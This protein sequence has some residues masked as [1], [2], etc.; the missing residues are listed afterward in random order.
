MATISIA[1][2]G[3]DT[4]ALTG[5]DW[6]LSAITGKTPAFQGVIP[7]AE[8]SLY[9]IHFGTDGKFVGKADCNAIAGTYTTNGKDRITITPG[10]ST[11]VACPEGSYGSLFVHG[12]EQVT[13]W[14]V[15]DKQLTLTTND[16]GTA[17]FDIGSGA[18]ASAPVATATA[19]ATASPAPARRPRPHRSPPPRPHRSPPRPRPR[20]RPHGRAPRPRGKATFVPAEFAPARELPDETYPLVLNTGRVLQH[21]HTGTMTRRAKALDEIAPEALLEMTPEDMQALGVADGE[22]VRVVSR[23]G[24]VM[25]KALGSHKPS[26]GSV[27]LPFHFKEAAGES[28]DD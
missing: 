5:K 25:V 17:T 4:D 21:W 9:T 24:E 23:R 15:A 22:F 27:F 6:W 2:C 8:Q 7:A 26:R 11:L 12:L 3:S 16:G 14:A 20:A 28:P 13:T 1:A 19:K 18:G 10:V